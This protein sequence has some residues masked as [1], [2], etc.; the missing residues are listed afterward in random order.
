MTNYSHS[1]DTLLKKLETLEEENEFLKAKYEHDIAEWKQAEKAI[2]NTIL[3]LEKSNSE[4]EKFFSI[5]AHELK[6]PFLG[7]LGLTGIMDIDSNK[8]SLEEFKLYS[9]AVHKS[10][11]N[12]Y[13]LIENL[14][15][16]AKLQNG[17]IAFSPQEL[18][19]FDVFLESKESIKL[20]ALQKGITI[21]NE[22]PENYKIYADEKMISSVFGNLLCNA[23]KFTQKN[24]RII[25][26]A[27]EREDGMMEISVKDTGIGIPRD[28]V[29]KLFTLGEDV[30]REGTDNEPST[31]LGLMLC[32]DFVEKHGG[33]IWVE[34]KEN[35]G[36]TFYFTLP[37]LKNIPMNGG[38]VSAGPCI[39]QLNQSKES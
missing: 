31:G 32:K 7:L 22:I 5:L 16:W 11:E 18:C 17:S 13:K 35:Y 10:M 28:L 15:E 14:L 19:L 25:V 12:L 24:R 29:G 38:K 20:R 2:Q 26:R 23:V 37:G 39:L 3:E 21:I 33:K 8:L 36:S 6:S 30:G 34:S 9:S 4:K 27:K 1:A